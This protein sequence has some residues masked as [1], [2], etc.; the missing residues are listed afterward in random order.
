V[1][2][3][4]DFIIKATL[5][6]CIDNDLLR[7]ICKFELKVSASGVTDEQLESYL[8]EFLKGSST[9]LGWSLDKYFEEMYGMNTVNPRSRIMDLM[10]Q[11]TE[12][13]TRYN[14]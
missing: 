3:Q 1:D 4:P 12:I 10:T 7:V 13:R 11:W 2:Q 8:N 9:H 14:L 6:T 5:K